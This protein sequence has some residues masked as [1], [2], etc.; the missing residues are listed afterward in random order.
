MEK[1]QRLYLLLIILIGFGL[2]LHYLNRPMHLDESTTVVLFA[3]QNIPSIVADYSAPNN[4]ILHSILVH[5]IYHHLGK[6]AF[7]LRLPAFISGLLLLPLGYVVARR[8][9][10]RQVALLTIGMVAVAPSLILFSI[11]AR[12]YTLMAAIILLLAWFAQHLKTQDVTRYWL[13]FGLFAALGFFTIPIMFYAMGGLALWLLA[14]IW[15]ENEG[16]QRIELLKNYTVSLIFAAVLT[17]VLY[18]PVFIFS[19]PQR[20]FNTQMA[21][22]TAAA[23]FYPQLLGIYRLMA[24]FP[25][26]DLPLPVVVMSALL[27]CIGLLAHR[28]LSATAMPLMLPFLIWILPLIAVQRVFPP[29]RTWVFLVPIFWMVVAAGAFDVLQRL[30]KQ[31]ALPH[32]RLAVLLLSSALALF[33]L[34][35]G[36]LR[37]SHH[38]GFS[39]DAELAALYIDEIL[40]PDDSLLMVY[41]SSYTVLYYS[42]LHNLQLG[43]DAQT[44]RDLS[45]DDDDDDDNDEAGKTYL[46]VHTNADETA[47]MNRLFPGLLD[48]SEVV[49]EFPSSELR[50]LIETPSITR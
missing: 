29:G 4:H 6:S 8:I 44:N 13:L 42:D 49:H 33:V 43:H 36:T 27:F 7:L 11:N 19:G 10:N 45:Q 5:L 14:A 12:G 30:R 46:F 48:N 34:Q 41:P 37:A 15:L 17:L 21:Q 18:T 9:Y 25:V 24:G 16:A 2:R 38:L 31:Q 28:R 39:E 26:L 35:S 22:P 40:Q 32:Y 50:R 3:S 20:L 23:E 47:E 1:L